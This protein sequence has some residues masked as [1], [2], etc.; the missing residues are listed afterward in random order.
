MISSGKHELDES[1][2][3]ATSSGLGLGPPTPAR[4]PRAYL[5][6]S[7]PH[8][9]PAKQ[10]SVSIGHVY[11]AMTFRRQKTRKKQNKYH[12]GGL[13]KTGGTLLQVPMGLYWGPPV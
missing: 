12:I 7:K 13:A 9:G 5:K 6:V 2:L 4:F 10:L 3:F 11:G 8:A 1:L